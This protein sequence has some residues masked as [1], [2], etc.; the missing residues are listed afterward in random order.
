MTLRQVVTEYIQW[1]REQEQDKKTCL[2]E[3]P[4]TLYPI[5]LHCCAAHRSYRPGIRPGILAD[6]I[7]GG[8]IDIKAGIMT[9]IMADTLA[10]RLSPPADSGSSDLPWHATGQTHRAKPW[11]HARW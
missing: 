11:S 5:R 4:I 10:A 1:W 3:T 9:G 2:G 7:A 8:L 6:I